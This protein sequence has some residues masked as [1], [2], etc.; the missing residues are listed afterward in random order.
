M[1]QSNFKD[2]L[3]KCFAY[4]AIYIIINLYMKMSNAFVFESWY[5]VGNIASASIGYLIVF[6]G[7]ESVNH[8]LSDTNKWKSKLSQMTISKS[9]IIFHGIIIVVFVGIAIAIGKL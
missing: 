5:Y 1:K 7:K 8:R 4:V 6:L 2:L 9:A 3:Y